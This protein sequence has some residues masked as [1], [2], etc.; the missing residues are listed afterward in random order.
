MQLGLPVPKKN[1]LFAQPH[2]LG[3]KASH[4]REDNYVTPLCPVAAQRYLFEKCSHNRLVLPDIHYYLNRFSLIMAN[5]V[6]EMR[7][8][9]KEEARHHNFIIGRIDMCETEEAW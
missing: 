3:R 8:K 9:E 2:V 4:D 5:P 7:P 6:S 1:P